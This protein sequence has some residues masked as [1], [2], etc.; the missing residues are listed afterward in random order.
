MPPLRPAARLVPAAEDVRAVRPPDLRPDRSSATLLSVGY[1]E[2]A[3]ER[4][5]VA[6]PRLPTRSFPA[7]G[8]VFMATQTVKWLN[9]AKRLEAKN[10]RPVA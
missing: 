7:G 1:A 10:V 6:P 4:V 8:G 9:D 3:H 2:S 5:S